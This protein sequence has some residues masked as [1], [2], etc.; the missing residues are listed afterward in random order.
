MGEQCSALRGVQVDA[1]KDAT[2]KGV[3]VSFL[4]R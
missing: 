4:P 3:K 2:V 1:K